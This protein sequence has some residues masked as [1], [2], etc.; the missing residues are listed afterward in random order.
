ME[1]DSEDARCGAG[2]NEFAEPLALRALL[3]AVDH[4]WQALATQARMRP[5]EIMALERL[6]ATGPMPS[7]EV[8]A[9]SLIDRFETSGLVRRIRPTLD[10]R[11]VLVELTPAGQEFTTALL[12]SL[13]THGGPGLLASAAPEPAARVRCLTD[14][15]ELLER[16][17]IISDDS[18]MMHLD[19]PERGARA[20]S[21]HQGGPR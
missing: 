3:R 1:T 12:D 4:V 11:T 21:L 6:H 13:I 2:A 10:R 17:A 7:R 19:A 20:L 9:T 8:G 18:C 5:V 15:A 14:A 16:A